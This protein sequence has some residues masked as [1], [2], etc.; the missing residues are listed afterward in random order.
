MDMKISYSIYI[1]FLMMRKEKYEFVSKDNNNNYDYFKSFEIFLINLLRF[2]INAWGID[3]IFF[4][5]RI[6]VTIAAGEFENRYRFW[7]CFQ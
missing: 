1:L 2:I 7:D 6:F 3:F 4:S 5:M